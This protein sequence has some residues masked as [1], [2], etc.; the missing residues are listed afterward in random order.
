[1]R[2]AENHNIQT[3]LQTKKRELTARLERINQ[4]VRRPLD[5]DF[6]ERAKE[7]EDQDVVDAL[8]IEGRLE[9]QKIDAALRAIERGDYGVCVECGARIAAERLRAY[10]YADRCIDCAEAAETATRVG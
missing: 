6:K 5:A 10:P 2:S 4:N 9:L 3:A 8:G 7:L 1:M